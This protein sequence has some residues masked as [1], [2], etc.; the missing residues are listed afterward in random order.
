MRAQAFFTPCANA[1][2]PA[3]TSFGLQLQTGQTGQ[4]GQA[5]H[6]LGGGQGVGGGQS[7]QRLPPTAGHVGHGGQVAVEVSPP[8]SPAGGGLS[9]ATCPPPPLAC[10]SK[11]IVR[12]SPSGKVSTT[13][14]SQYA[15]PWMPLSCVP[16]RHFLWLS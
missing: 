2:L 6:T 8:S 15:T 4:A 7:G 14:P 12:R 13:R 10:E 11:L 16:V 9:A 3:S 1:A 5:G